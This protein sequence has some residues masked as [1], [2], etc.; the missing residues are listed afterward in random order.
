MNGALGGGGRPENGGLRRST[1][2]LNTFAYLIVNVDSDFAHNETLTKGMCSESCDLFK[3]W[4][5]CYNIS[6]TVQDRD[7]VAMEHY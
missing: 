5:I 4:E 7:T 2:K 6:T 1:K 3:F